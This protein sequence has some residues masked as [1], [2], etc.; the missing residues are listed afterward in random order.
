MTITFIPGEVNRN[1]H[2]VAQT[3]W[4]NH[5]IIVYGSGNNLIITGGTIQPANKNPN[6]FN[7]DKNL[8]TIYLNRDPQSI[9]INPKNGYIIIAITNKVIVYKPMN[10]YMKI[11]KWQSCTEFEIPD[12]MTINCVKWANEED[13]IVIGTNNSLCLYHLYNEYGE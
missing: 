3:N 13:E 9:D 8:Q 2:S 5:H 12:D 6:P 7:I 10:E 4:K 1:N 11:P